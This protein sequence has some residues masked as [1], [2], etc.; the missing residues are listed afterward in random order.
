M[1]TGL[2]SKLAP[3]LRFQKLFPHSIRCQRL[4]RAVCDRPKKSYSLMATSIPPFSKVILLNHV[5]Q[6][7]MESWVGG[8]HTP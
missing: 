1:L 6:C 7:Y 2:I 8:S 5:I 4:G 3:Q